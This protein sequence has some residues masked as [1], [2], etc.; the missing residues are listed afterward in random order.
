M[1]SLAIM[2]ISFGEFSLAFYFFSFFQ[3]VLYCSNQCSLMV[4]SMDCE[5]RK[6]WLKTG[7]QLFFVLFQADCFTCLPFNFVMY[8]MEI[9]IVP[10]SHIRVE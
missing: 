10:H 4:K 7:S 3:A 2:S 1:I 9:L 6:P 8:E 5:V